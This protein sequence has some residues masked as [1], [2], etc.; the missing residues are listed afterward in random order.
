MDQME[1]LPIVNQC[2]QTWWNLQCQVNDFYSERERERPPLSQ[3]KGFRAIKN[4]IIQ[5]AEHILITRRISD[6]YS[7]CSLVLCVLQ[8]RQYT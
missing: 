7:P 5:E 2:Y 8:R 4:A 1:R 3:Q 6:S